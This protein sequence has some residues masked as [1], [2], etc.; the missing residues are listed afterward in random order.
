MADQFSAY[1]ASQAQ[2]MFRIGRMAWERGLCAANDGNFS[3]CLED[4]KILCTASGI[5]KGFMTE[6]DLAVIDAQGQKLSGGG[7]ASSEIK[8][9]LAAY[10]SRKDVKVVVHLHPPYTLAVSLITHES[11]MYDIPLMA[12]NLIGLGK[13]PVLPFALPGSDEIPEG[14][15]PYF[16][17]CEIPVL[18]H[19][20]VVAWG[21]TLEDAYYKLETL[22]GTK[23][24]YRHFP[25]VGRF[26]P[27]GYGSQPASELRSCYFP[28]R[29]IWTIL[30]DFC[31]S[32]S[33]LIKAIKKTV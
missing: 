33:M 7:K 11:F 8:M 5:S 2:I 26:R 23:V 4:G 22:K 19:H 29:T 13:V 31:S 15:K 10:Y 12:E 16:N 24:C 30:I 1:A 17:R 6:S 20:G 18:A 3:C 27:F 14:L 9:H 21:K 32:L 28:D 25:V